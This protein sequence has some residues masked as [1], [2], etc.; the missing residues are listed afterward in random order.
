M[1]KTRDTYKYYFKKGN[2]IVHGGIT[3]NLER[4]KQEHKQKWPN[5]H[6][7]QVGR[8]TAE[9]AAREWEQKKGFAYERL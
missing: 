6:I 3:D 5:G 9:D 2:R 1:G 8:R 4:R 7:F